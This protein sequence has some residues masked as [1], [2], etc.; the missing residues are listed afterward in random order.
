MKRTLICGHSVRI[1][2]IREARDGTCFNSGNATG[3]P[4]RETTAASAAR[5][6]HHTP[7]PRDDAHRIDQESDHRFPRDGDRDIGPR[8]R[9]AVFGALAQKCALVGRH[10]RTR[11]AGNR[12]R[13]LARAC[14]EGQ[15]Q[16]SYSEPRSGRRQPCSSRRTGSPLAPTQKAQPRSGR[17]PPCC[18][19]PRG[20]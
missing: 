15:A 13:G 2:A 19:D 14:R 20:E 12:R 1:Q 16:F 5:T 8:Q 4:Q 18:P 10:G 6:L 11:E 3:Q 9:R 7:S 17:R